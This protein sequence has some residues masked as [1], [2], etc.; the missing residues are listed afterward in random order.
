MNGA[1]NLSGTGIPQMFQSIE[2]GWINYQNAPPGFVAWIDE[3][4]IDS[5][6]V[7]CAN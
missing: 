5:T 1:G 7:G 6:R 2:V 3:L 4:A